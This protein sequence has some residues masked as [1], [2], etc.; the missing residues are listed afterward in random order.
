MT[1]ALAVK[2]DKR[3]VLTKTLLRAGQGLG[4]DQAA[5]ARVIGMERSVFRRGVDPN[6]KA[7]ELGLLLIRCYRSLFALMGGDP[8]H[9]RH[10]MHTPNH[11][12][13]G[14]P[15]AQVQTVEGLVH[16]LSYLDAI[17]GKV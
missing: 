12:T 15:A 6:S 10:W 16:V 9:M 7:G 17:R 2:D 13:G 5:L 1:S 8:D 14:V 11:H 4:L 3:A